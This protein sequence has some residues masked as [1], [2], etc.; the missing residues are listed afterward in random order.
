[1]FPK[2][3]LLL[4]GPPVIYALCFSTHG[5]KSGGKVAK[6][7]LPARPTATLSLL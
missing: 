2:R 6:T 3:L 7:V 1:M 5:S 4:L